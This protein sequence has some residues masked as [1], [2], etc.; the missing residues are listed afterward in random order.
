MKN[1]ER[2]TNRELIPLTKLI[3]NRPATDPS[4]PEPLGQFLPEWFD[5]NVLRPGQALA[6]VEPLWNS[7]PPLLQRSCKLM[8]VRRSTLYIACDHPTAEAEMNTLLRSG[9]RD[10]IQRA[11]HGRVNRVKTLAGRDAY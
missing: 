5:K 10:K 8:A 11:S 6:W 1:R 2:G 9:L 4:P 3:K 7:L